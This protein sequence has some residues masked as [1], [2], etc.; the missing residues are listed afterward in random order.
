[1]IADDGPL[2]EC[3]FFFKS[4]FPFSSFTPDIKYFLK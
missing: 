1:M 3:N 4:N 2:K